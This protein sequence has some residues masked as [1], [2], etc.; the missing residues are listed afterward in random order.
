[1]SFPP[2][3]DTSR[4][5]IRKAGEVLALDESDYIGGS[6]NARTIL[7]Q[8]RACHGFPLDAFARELLDRA[9]QLQTHVIVAQRLKRLFRIVGKL[10]QFPTMNATTM[11][12]IAGL[13]AI[14][15]NVQSVYS[16]LQSYQD[17]PLAIGRTLEVTDYTDYIAEPKENGYRSIHVSLRYESAT[18]SEYNGLRAEL[19]LRTELQ[20]LWASAVEITGMW[21]GEQI[22]YDEGHPLWTEFFALVAELIARQETTARSDQY[23]SLSNE[24]VRENLIE[25]ERELNAVH[26]MRQE[27]QS[28]TVVLEEEQTAGDGEGCRL[29][30]L[31]R[32]FKHLRITAFPMDEMDKATVAFTEAEQQVTFSDGRPAPVLVSVSSEEKLR[33]AYRTFF[34]DIGP[35][36]DLVEVLMVPTK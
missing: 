25:V 14:A 32:E 11:Q 34:L 19:Q 1:M 36:A 13:R 24:E 6:E 5:Q 20:H 23:A 33:E 31:D 3:P 21:S 2:V 27:I 16:V 29:L 17:N 26:Y 9:E 30:Q 7:S 15:D 28:P 8:W 22:K 18:A 35:F 10:K 4:N 12:D